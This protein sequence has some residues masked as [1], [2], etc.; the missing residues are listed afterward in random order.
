MSGPLRLRVDHRSIHTTTSRD[1]DHLFLEGTVTS[2]AGACVG[3][4]VEYRL[5]VRQYLDVLDRF[6][7]APADAEVRRH[8]ANLVAEYLRDRA[9][10]ARSD[11][12][13]NPLA[14][15]IDR[16]WTMLEDEQTGRIE[17][18]EVLPPIGELPRSVDC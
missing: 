12:T 14:I 11:E 17:S 2:G 1:T 3:R 5:T 7:A 6:L 13:A 10:I 8:R 15:A 18:A 16:A 4:D 9:S